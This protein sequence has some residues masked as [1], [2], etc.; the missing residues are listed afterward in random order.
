MNKVTKN[1]G[2]K[3]MKKTIGA[4]TL[5]MMVC[6]TYAVTGRDSSNENRL[7]NNIDSLKEVDLDDT[8]QQKLK[9]LKQELATLWD[10]QDI[11]SKPLDVEI[12]SSETQQGIITQGLYFNGAVTSAGT[13]R[14]FAW[15]SRPEK[16][17]TKLPVYIEITG[18]SKNIDSPAWMSRTWKC[19]VLNIEWRG[20]SNPNRSKWAGGR[21]DPMKQMDSL[22]AA[23]PYRLV[24]GIRR[25]IDFIETQP[26]LDL[27]RIACG[28][29]SMGG[30]Y[31]LLAAGVDSRIR[32]GMDELG[33]GC[34]ANPGSSLARFSMSAP[35]KEL[36]LQAFDPYSYARSTQA[37]IIMNL[38]SDDYF[39]WLN[40]CV[41]NYEL[42]PAGKRL[43]ITPNYNHND[44]SFGQ[45]KNG[46]MGFLHTCFGQWDSYP[47]IAQSTYDGETCSVTAAGIQESAEAWLYWSPGTDKLAWSSRYWKKIKAV[48]KG[49]NRFEAEIPSKYRKLAGYAFMNVKDGRGLASSIPQYKAGLDPQQSDL[50]WENDQL[51]DVEQGIAAW[52]PVG[53][54]MPSGRSHHPATHIEVLPDNVIALGPKD[55]SMDSFAV[56]NNS[57]IL[58]SGQAL[59]HKGLRV[60]IDGKAQAGQ[61]TVTL[62]Q[63]YAA[64]EIQREYSARIHY[65]LGKQTYPLRWADFKNENG[66][67]S[68]LPFDGLRLDGK[69]TDGSFLTI[70]IQKL[71]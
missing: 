66:E 55:A 60:I 36:W 64:A 51:W 15:Y 31:T 5:L 4:A 19:A 65:G 26:D 59:K 41:A 16:T 3:M 7:L 49:N 50:L 23:L 34:L 54:A 47:E 1:K 28:G 61:L 56:V 12:V 45:K 71:D 46:A 30:Y 62:V 42:L 70:N 32:F 22:R 57:V 67:S 35:F 24:T 43:S 33:G 52:R 10:Y 37:K 14:I 38:S 2:T 69:R 39:F 9:E 29:G 63:N 21:T 20:A 27:Q 17:D 25:G 58:A 8:S 40:D 48:A 6:T 68:P 13:D 53:F 44:G 11:G 18:G